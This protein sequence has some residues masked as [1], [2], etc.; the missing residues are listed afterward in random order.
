MFLFKI[1]PETF[2]VRTAVI[3]VGSSVQ[4]QLAYLTE[5][6]FTNTAFKR[7]FSR[8]DVNVF[9]KVLLANE[10][11]LALLTFVLLSFQVVDVHV[12]LK[13]KF[14]GVASAAAGKH[15]AVQNLVVLFNYF[16]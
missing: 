16:H 9:S 5:P 7:F 11:F 8:V 13:V 4:S 14:G 10:S 2:G 12:A 15:T 6:F 3:V 1:G